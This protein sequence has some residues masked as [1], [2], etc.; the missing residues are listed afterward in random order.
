VGVGGC[1][2]DMRNAHGVSVGNHLIDVGVGR[3][4]IWKSV[5]KEQ[6]VRVWTGIVWFR[7]GSNRGLCPIRPRE[8]FGYIGEAIRNLLASWACTEKFVGHPTLMFMWIWYPLLVSTE[9][10]GVAVTLYIPT[11]SVI[12]SD[13]AETLAIVTEFLRHFPWSLQSKCLSSASNR[14]RPHLPSPFQFIIINRLN[15]SRFEIRA[16]GRIHQWIS[17]A[18]VYNTSIEGGWER[19]A[20]GCLDVLHNEEFHD[21]YPALDNSRLIE[22]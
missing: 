1:V 17:V 11:R 21:L 13:L 22:S 5:L 14:S 2:W 19:G 3:W 20:E 15:A 12:G 6:A 18:C 10:V 8:P 4:T 9:R 7:M 16:T